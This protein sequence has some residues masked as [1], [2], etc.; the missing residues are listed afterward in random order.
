[1]AKHEVD[2]GGAIEV[3]VPV[4]FLVSV[5]PY[6]PGEQA[7]FPP[8][9]AKD[10]VQYGLAAYVDPADGEEAEKDAAEAKVEESRAP[11]AGRSK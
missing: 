7:G 11:K 6:N 3:R 1:V 2:L 4:R 10:L 5:A 9:I 8:E